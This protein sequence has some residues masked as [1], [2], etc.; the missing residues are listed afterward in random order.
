MHQRI[1]N[2]SV[3]GG[4]RTDLAAQNKFDEDQVS[5]PVHSGLTD[6]DVE[7]IIDTIKKQ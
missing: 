4:V 2:N 1:D 7:L 5:I 6:E 3:F